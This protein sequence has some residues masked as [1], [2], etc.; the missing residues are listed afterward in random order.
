MLVFMAEVCPHCPAV[1]RAALQLAVFQPVISAVIIDAVRFSDLADQFKVKATPTIVIDGGLTIVGRIVASDLAEKITTLS[2]PDSMTAILDSMIKSGRA[3]DA[4]ELIVQEKKPEAM[5]PI[6]MAKEF[7]VRM[8][9]L[10]A[11]ESALEKD[12]RILDSIVKELLDLLSDEEVG[13][14][15]DTAELLGKLGIQLPYPL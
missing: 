7:S 14:R 1:V 12:P 3:E 11:F 13:L 2:K 4:A 5:L 8:G 10:V 15:G 6:Y 9:A